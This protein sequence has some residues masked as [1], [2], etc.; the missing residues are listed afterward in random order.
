V[1]SHPRLRPQLK[2]IVNDYREI[3]DALSTGAE[4]QPKYL[5]GI[6]FGGLVLLNVIGGGVQFDKAVIDST[7]SRVSQ[8]DCPAQYDSVRNLPADGLRLFVKSGARDT[9][10]RPADQA[11]LR[12]MAQ[13][14]GAGVVIFEEFAHPFMDRDPSTHRHRQ[15][16][17]KDFLQLAV[18]IF[19]AD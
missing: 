17:V 11:E 18:Q 3:F 6:S 19:R 8:M 16:I 15:Q 13:V 5:Y 2:A 12:S 1:W 14:P 10:V 4:A 7:P 9:V